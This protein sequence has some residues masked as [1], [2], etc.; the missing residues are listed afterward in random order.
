MQ[1]LTIVLN[2]APKL[3]H[4]LKLKILTMKTT[5]HAG[6]TRPVLTQTQNNTTLWIGHLQ[7]DPTDHVGGQTFKCPSEGLLDNIQLYSSAVQY[8]GEVL[9]TFHEFDSNTKTWGPSIGNSSLVLQRD[10]NARWIRFSFLPVQLQR[11]IT[12]GFRLQSKEALVAI[13]EAATGNKHPFTFGHE[14]N[15]DSKNKIGHY[16]TY[17]SLAF[18]VEMCA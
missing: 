7:S 4:V 9:L 1:L 14:W 17:F 10:D 5:K 2:S 16:F 8:P 12:Y 6:H 3:L 15:A 18:K 11:D 13:G